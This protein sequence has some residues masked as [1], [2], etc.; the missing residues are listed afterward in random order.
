MK[1][2]QLYRLSPADINKGAEVLKDAFM[3]Y[4]AF[5][6]L[7][8]EEQKRELKLKYLMTFFIKC[9]LLK[10]EVYAPSKDIEGI[11][12]W[13]NSRQ[14]NLSFRD[15]LGGGLLNLLFGL[16]L[17]SFIKLI[18]LGN[19]KKSNRNRLMNSE[20]YFL[21]VI[22]INPAFARIGLGKLLI[23]A[24]MEQIKEQNMCCFLETGK[25]EN[26]EYYKRY[27]FYLL[28]EY[29]YN[30]LRSYCLLKK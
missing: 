26:I 22:G 28:S 12:I 14:L 24:K 1:I 3:N 30:G 7:F 4:P 17:A 18:K 25:T 5:K 21:D 19:A 23:E 16:K 13:Y 27:G 10:G 20:Y 29:D 9:G 15:Y 8:P 6:N 2:N 11:A